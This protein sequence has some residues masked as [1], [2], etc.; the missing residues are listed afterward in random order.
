[1]DAAGGNPA[2]KIFAALMEVTADTPF[3]WLERKST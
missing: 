1:M 3:D 2:E